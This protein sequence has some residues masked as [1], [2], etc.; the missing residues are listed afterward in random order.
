[1]KK[2]KKIL[3]FIILFT[4]MNSVVYFIGTLNEEQRIQVA[5]NTHL[6]KVETH[7][8]ILLHHQKITADAVYM[9]TVNKKKVINIL[10]QIE[11]A[12]SK[13][14]D[15]LREELFQF[16]QDKYK[17]LKS[18]GVLQY[19]FVLPNNI[20]FLRMH[21]PSKFGDDLSKIRYSFAYT[22]KTHKQVHGFEQGKTTHGFRNIYPIYDDKKH[23]LG[24]I[25]VAFSSEFLQ[26]YLTKVSKIHTHFLI[27]KKVFDT[28]AWNRDDMV[29]KYRQSIEHPNYMMSLLNSSDKNKH[30]IDDFQKVLLIKKKIYENMNK[31][32]PFSLNTM[33]RC[34][35]KS[36][37]IS[38]YPIKNIKEKKVVAWIVSYD[39]DD[40]IDM[41]FMMD[42][43]IRS[44]TFFVFLVLFYFAYRVF[45][46]KEILDIQV[47]KKTKELAES[48]AELQYLNKN[49][50][51]TIE[52][53]V[54][55]NH[56]KD[57]LLFQQ[58]KMASMGE[59]IGNIAHQWRQPIA[60]ISMWANNIIADVDMDEIDNDNLRKYANNINTQ[61][62]HLS[63]TIDDFRNF[64][65]PNKEKSTFIIKE[66]IDKTMNL[67]SA[68]FKSHSIEIVK[69]IADI[70][71]TT[72]ENELTQ[73]MLN[74]IK[75]A[76]DVLIVLPRDT[77]K[78]IFINVYQKDDFVNIEIIDNGGGVS[79]DILEKVFEPYF[80]TKHK[81]QGTGIGLY[82][83]E[84]IITKH[85]HGEID[86]DNYS[87][88]YKNQS[89]TGARFIIKLPL[90]IKS[91]LKK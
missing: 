40:F 22:N 43:Y 14:L 44:I 9:S 55:K 26:N 17:I 67:L 12:D 79:A 81:S 19:H 74:I 59:M 28:K 80:T 56:E 85:L 23:Y 47:K 7:Y 41:T 32:K 57:R 21:K 36:I 2:L 76:K 90:D 73:A 65:S 53:E 69:D 48:K 70:E 68:S 39:Y 25:D 61:T 11:K 72:L 89:Y 64:F 15:I 51:L 13:K 16:L 78:L 5:L 87:Y 24:S 6:A 82:M 29:F 88:S 75:N 42:F 77:L 30:L 18:K 4:L 27:H 38:F 52:H 71:V 49:L 33:D 66:S 34:E 37:V 58:S 84:A 20:V 54:K 46:Q 31:N 62:K 50:K 8:K 45:N 3:L 63:E 60:V 10:S 1:M 91:V 83:T 86:V 35:K